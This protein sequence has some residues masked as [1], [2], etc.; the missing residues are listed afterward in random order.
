MNSGTPWL[1]FF[2]QTIHLKNKFRFCKQRMILFCFSS[3]WTVNSCATWSSEPWNKASPPLWCSK[4]CVKP[5]SAK[6]M[7]KPLEML[8]CSNHGDDFSCW[9]IK[10]NTKKFQLELCKLFCGSHREIR[11]YNKFL[12][13]LLWSFDLENLD[14]WMGMHFQTNIDPR[15]VCWMW[16]RNSERLSQLLSLEKCF[17]WKPAVADCSCKFM[18]SRS[19][20]KGKW[21]AQIILK[22]KENKK[23][24]WITVEFCHFCEGMALQKSTVFIQS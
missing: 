13:P 6:Q 9:L 14:P 24:C 8:D 15:R 16:F 3:E 5:E 22:S 18:Q 11:C 19:V 7:L 17:N 21:L 2:I 23:S 12:G 4:V 20:A 10:T 1:V